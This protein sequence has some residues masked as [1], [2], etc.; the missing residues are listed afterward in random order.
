MAFEDIKEKSQKYLFQNYGRQDLCFAYGEGS[1]L[2]DVSGK[3]YLDMVAGIA[4][5]SVGHSHPYWVEAVSQQAGRLVHTSN[6]YQVE[7]Q[8]ELAEKIASVTPPGM[9]KTLFVNSG[10]EA[11]EAALKIAVR[12]TGRTKV[13]SA[14][15]SFHGRTAGALGAT[16]QTKYQDTFQPLISGNY[17]YFEFGNLE[18][19]KEKICKDTAAVILEPIQG[20]G[21]VQTA[22]KEFFKGVRD[23]CSDNGTLMIMDEVQTG[24][25]RTGKWFGI[26]HYDVVPDIMTLAKGLGGGVPIGAA[27]TTDD[28]AGI[29]TPGTHG[30]TFGGNPLVCA[31]GSAVIDIIK[32]EKLVENAKKLGDLLM[33]ELKSVKHPEIT[34]VRG[35][36][37]LIGVEIKSKSKEFQD[38]ALKCGMLVNICHGNVLRLMPPLNITEDETEIFMHLF[39]KFFR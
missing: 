29:L 7:K 30:T 34:D 5:N 36:G 31:A 9:N 38:F 18:S 11:N 37:L 15:N 16:G 25:A 8:V 32:E 2:T 27:V 1:Y 17:D 21:G 28:I 6:L 23:I 39:R 3:Q 24:I 20:E 13:L 12:K 26:Q 33:K 14:L 22:S 10:A 35:K 19:L 4:V